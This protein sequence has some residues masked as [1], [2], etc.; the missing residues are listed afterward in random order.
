M[1]EVEGWP[2][3]KPMEEKMDNESIIIC[4]L[5]DSLMENRVTKVDTTLVKLIVK[6]RE[7]LRPEQRKQFNNIIDLI[8]IADSEYAYKTFKCGIRYCLE[9]Q[10]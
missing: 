2:P 10:Q 8:N 6:F 4:D 5:C 7:V 3:S 9:L 1:R